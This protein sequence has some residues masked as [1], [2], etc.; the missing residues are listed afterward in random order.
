VVVVTIIVGIVIV[1]KGVESA[2]LVIATSIVFV[3]S[4]VRYWL[5]IEKDGSNGGQDQEG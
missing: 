5:R 3:A 1:A 4:S 2:F